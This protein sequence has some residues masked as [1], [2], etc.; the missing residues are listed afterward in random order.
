M[1]NPRF[2]LS[3]ELWGC[4]CGTPRNEH[5]HDALTKLFVTI[6]TAIMHDFLIHSITADVHRQWM[7]HS[8]DYRRFITWYAFGKFNDSVDAR[9]DEHSKFLEHCTPERNRLILDRQQ[10]NSLELCMRQLLHHANRR[11]TKRQF[12][13]S[14]NVNTC[15]ALT[16]QTVW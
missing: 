9:R 4:N 12:V 2:I 5:K 14:D 16:L 15:S 3:N 6:I 13:Q 8:N 7:T 1:L 10:L 11:L